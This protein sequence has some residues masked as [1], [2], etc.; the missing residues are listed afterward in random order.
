MTGASLSRL[1]AAVL[2][3]APSVASAQAADQ[4]PVIGLEEARRRALGVAP[5]AVAARSLVETATWARRSAF[6]RLVS[7]DVTARGDYLHFSDPFFNFGTGGISPNSASATIEAR[8]TVLGAGRISAFRGTRA[9]LAS[10]EATETATRYRTTLVTDAAYFAV[11]AEQQLAKVAA[12]RLRRAEQQFTIARVRVEAGEAIASDSLQ[13]LIEVNAA[14]LAVLKSDSAVASA[15]LQLGRRV[16]LAH[17]VDASP[18]DTAVLAP[19]PVSEAA[20]TAE[21]L[22]RGPDLEA[23][24]ASE[25]QADALVDMERERYLPEISVGAAAGAYDSRFFPSALKRSQL[26]VSVAVPIWNGGQ[27]EF[28]VAAA[29]AQYNIARAERADLER[30]A[31]QIM[32]QAFYGYST[33]LKSIE[34]A[35]VGVAAA[36]EYFRVQQARYREGATTIL[37]LVAAQ[38]SLSEAESAL[39]LSRYAAQLALAQIEALLG[40]RIFGTSAS[41]GSGR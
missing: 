35:R 15:R 2:V 13:L 9:S 5:E 11:I 36:T 29:R 30:G 19:L 10:A 33:A 25:A 28:S 22:E 37:D 4:Y 1:V 3:V 31:G 23:A 8:Y 6:S 18:A 39:V 32:T 17:P 41:N 24:R 27:R 20:L 26:A 14:R 7:P 40:R 12:D 34:L 21:F 38:E 16:G